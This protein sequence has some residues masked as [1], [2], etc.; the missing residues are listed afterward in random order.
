MRRL[1]YVKGS[2]K[3]EWLKDMLKSKARDGTIIE[4][5][6]ADYENVESKKNLDVTNTTRYEKHMLKTIC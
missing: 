1:S 5:L 4:T 3:R 2:Q 6:N